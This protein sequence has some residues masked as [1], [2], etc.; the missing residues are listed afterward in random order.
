MYAY[1]FCCVLR[2][3]E[4][5]KYWDSD[6]FCCFGSVLSTLIRGCFHPCWVNRW[7]VTAL[8][9]LSPLILGDRVFR[10]IHLCVN[11][12]YK[13][14]CDITSEQILIF[15]NGLGTVG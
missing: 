10:Q 11:K 9:V 12:K 1:C 4:L 3:S 7:R 8:F 14:D 2:Y 13:N 5:Q 6:T 15:N